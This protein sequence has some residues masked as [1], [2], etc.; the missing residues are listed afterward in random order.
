MAYF[1][2]LAATVA[3]WSGSHGGGISYG[4]VGGERT[5]G[6]GG[7]RSSH[8]RRTPLSK[9]TRAAL[10]QVLHYAFAANS[11][12]GCDQFVYFD[13]ANPKACLSP[14]AFVRLGDPDSK[15]KSWKVWERGAPHLAVEIV[16]ASDLHE[17]P[18]EIKLARY[19]QL[20]RVLEAALARRQG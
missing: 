9:G 10:Y 1:T 6:P 15:F 2:K 4:D 5:R 12:I 16:S 19:R 18:W 17:E 11:S 14:D 7:L 20:V 13:A 8:D 3:D